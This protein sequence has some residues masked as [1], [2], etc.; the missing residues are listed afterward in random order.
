MV[1]H[2]LDCL[3]HHLDN[4]G[5]QFYTTWVGNK[6]IHVD[7]DGQIRYLCKQRMHHR[8][9]VKLCIVVALVGWTVSLK[10]FVTMVTPVPKINYESLRTVLIN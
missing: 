9:Q 2:H 5:M 3:V 7:G 10:V 8:Q 4:S 6:V 1:H